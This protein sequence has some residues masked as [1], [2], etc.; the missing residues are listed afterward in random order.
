[1]STVFFADSRCYDVEYYVVANRIRDF[2]IS[3]VDVSPF[4]ETAV[5]ARKF[6]ENVAFKY[7]DCFV[8]D[9]IEFFCSQEDPDRQELL[10]KIILA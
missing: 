8:D 1:M 9:R 4:F 5:Q 3:K 2:G 6:K 10:S 7:P